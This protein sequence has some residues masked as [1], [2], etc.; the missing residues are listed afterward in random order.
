MNDVNF[1][2]LGCGGIGRRALEVSTHEEELTPVAACDRHG[3]AVDF[4]VLES[5]R[6][7]SSPSE[8]RSA[9]EDGLD[10]DELL[11][12]TEGNV[13]SDGGATAVKQSGERKGV[14]AST[15]ATPTDQP[16]QDVIDVSEGIDAVLVA[17]PNQIGR[18]HV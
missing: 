12:A 16:I 6:D 5:Q 1:A 17:L 11:A 9:S 10:V 4:D 3:V 15:Q 8:A 2:V 14:A 13:A 18:A 7:S